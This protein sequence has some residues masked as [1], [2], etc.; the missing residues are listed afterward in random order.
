MPISYSTC[1]ICHESYPNE[2]LSSVE[3]A[4]LGVAY[5]ICPTCT[6]DSINAAESRSLHGDE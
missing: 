1:D 6:L 5:E 2:E 4:Y 3:S